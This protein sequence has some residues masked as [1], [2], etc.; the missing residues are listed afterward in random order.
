MRQLL[1]CFIAAA[2][3]VGAFAQK[4]TSL[5]GKW[6]FDVA[7]SVT[8]EPVKSM[9]VV[10]SKDTP[11]MLSWRADSIDAQGKAESESWSGPE[12]G[13]MHPTMVDGKAGY[14]QSVKLEQD[15]TLVR[16]G[17]PPD[18]GSFEGHGKLSADGQTFVEE[19]VTKTKDGKEIKE[20]GVFH[21]VPKS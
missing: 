5:V 14:S 12:D 1:V 2:L 19:L 17:N 8:A 6:K 13:S 7:Q 3:A 18:G 4:K 15:G 11:Q 9:T 10:F 20:K 21:L 16:R